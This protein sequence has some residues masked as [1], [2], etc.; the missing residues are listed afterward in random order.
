MAFRPACRIPRSLPWCRIPSA[1]RSFCST[2]SRSMRFTVDLGAENKDL[3]A[4][5]QSFRKQGKLDNPFHQNAAVI[6]ATPQYA[7]CIDDEKF[8]KDFVDFIAGYQKLEQFH[9]LCAVV[10]H[11]APPVP[12]NT[13]IRGLA[14]F[15]GDLDSILPDLWAPELPRPSEDADKVAALTINFGNPQVTVP[16]ANTTFVN[17][18][19]STL[20]A[21]RFDLTRRYPRMVERIEKHRQQITPLMMDELRSIKE[22]G[23][24]APLVPLTYPR[25]VTESFGN[26][27]R[28]VEVD[29]ESTPASSELE[30]TVDQ[31]HKTKS[32]LVQTAMGV[33]A[34]VTPPSFSE[35]GISNTPSLNDLDPAKTFE[36][37]HPAP[38]LVSSTSKHLQRLYGQ[39]GRLYQILSGGGGWG[40]KKGLLS[41]DP[42]RTHFSL[43]EEEEMQRFMQAMDGDNLV[44]VGSSIQF[45]ASTETTVELSDGSFTGL[46]FG[47]PGMPSSPSEEPSHND[48]LIHND[49]FGALSNEGIFVTS[50]EDVV[51][52][53]SGHNTEWRFNVPHSRVFIGESKAALN[54]PNTQ[55][56]GGGS[57]IGEARSAWQKIVGSRSK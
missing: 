38:Q 10:D 41:L 22:L 29:S 54:V 36:E 32:Y 18:K 14:V 21:S 51:T 44:P 35:A 50:S 40:A 16:L 23:L 7:K 24:W 26:I 39:G 34:M 56:F 12:E 20:T 57:D 15:R 52:Q 9:L 8:L 6:L 43:S 37:N 19:T 25:V 42:Q 28:R 4:L 27:V 1:S 47:T 55:V 5:L 17:H 2:R 46:V 31:L 49:Q 30:P 3:P 45:F 53:M 11:I 48:F 13:P 33:W